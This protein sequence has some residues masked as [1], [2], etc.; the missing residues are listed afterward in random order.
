LRFE[1]PSFAAQMGFGVP[2]GKDR[3]GGGF[4]SPLMLGDAEIPTSLATA[5]LS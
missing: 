1:R 4:F 5:L 2:I 3:V